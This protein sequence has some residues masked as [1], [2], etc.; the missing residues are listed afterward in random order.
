[1]AQSFFSASAQDSLGSRAEAIAAMS[2]SF[3]TMLLVY[4]SMAARCCK[5]LGKV[6]PKSPIR[7]N[8]DS[9][10]SLL[11]VRD[12]QNSSSLN[13]VPSWAFVALQGLLSTV[14]DRAQC[15]SGNNK[16]GFTTF[17]R[18]RGAGLWKSLGPLGQSDL[19]LKLSTSGSCN[20]VPSSVC[21]RFTMPM[22][23][24][25]WHLSLSVVFC[26]GFA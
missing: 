13:E 2:K 8:H 4:G 24:V 19:R 17:H 6:L 11:S 14:P 15:S 1:M 22:L 5:W 16:I 18:A 21:S 7:L 26:V 9:M 20:L 12:L 3:G 25:S 10:L 23:D